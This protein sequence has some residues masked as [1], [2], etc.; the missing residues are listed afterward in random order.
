MNKIHFTETN[1]QFVG[2]AGIRVLGLKK[3]M[4]NEKVICGKWSFFVTEVPILARCHS[5]MGG[6][7]SKKTEIY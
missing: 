4:V 7:L 3:K 1:P 2:Y 5:Q 6:F